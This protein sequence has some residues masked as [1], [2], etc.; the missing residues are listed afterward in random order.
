MTIKVQ[1]SPYALKSNEILTQRFQ[2]VFSPLNELL[3]SLHVLLNPRHHGTNIRWALTTMKKLD[4]STI[5]D[6]NYF[7]LFYEMGTPA[8]LLN[9]FAFNVSSLDDEIG[10]LKRTMQ[11]EKNVQ[12]LIEELDNLENERQNSFIPQLAKSLEWQDFNFHKTTLIDDLR[13]NPS[14]VFV[15]FFKFI[16]RYQRRFFDAVWQEQE[17][18]NQLTSEINYQSDI[19]QKNGIIRM[20]NHLQVDRL[21]WRNNQ[22]VINKPFE[23]TI[24]LNDSDTVMLIPSCFV[25]PHLFV[26][27]FANGMVITYSCYQEQQIITTPTELL[28]TLKATA[29]PVRLQI[30]KSLA[31]NPSTTQALAQ[32]LSLGNSTVSRHLQILKDAGLLKSSKNKKYVVYSLTNRLFELMPNFLSYLN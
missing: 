14:E 32:V 10:I 23:R 16:T 20:I 9:N 26:D 22:L 21:H 13:S 19:I 31:N 24:K 29:D 15:R 8:S 11:S 27:S 18:F 25:W 4:H 12:A 17:L 28:T 2:F 1:F 3:R 7:S 30:I 5:E 6:L